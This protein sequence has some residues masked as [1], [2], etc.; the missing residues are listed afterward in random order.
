MSACKLVSKWKA[1]LMSNN[2]IIDGA[3][4]ATR[5][6]NPHLFPQVAI[7][8]KLPPGT[9]LVVPPS[10][11]EKAVVIVNIGK[12]KSVEDQL[13]RTERRWLETNRALYPKPFGITLRLANGVKFTPDFYV[14]PM[15]GG[16]CSKPTFFET[17]GAYIR[18][19]A[20]TKLKM[21][22]SLF[23]EF[24]FIMAQWK[25]GQW[26]ETEIKP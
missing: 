10:H 22:A 23:S 8:D 7:N 12:R 20:W 5:K 21:A 3:N 9:L 4:E 16:I 17:K 13:N 11:P 15:G 25:D 18:P 1:C 2:K 14:A 24:T 6:R 19:D 26:T